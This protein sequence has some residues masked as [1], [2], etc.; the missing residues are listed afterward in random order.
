MLQAS[1]VS[2]QVRVGTKQAITIIIVDMCPIVRR[3]LVSL[4]HSIPTFAVVTDVATPE[5]AYI[6][7]SDGTIDIAMMDLDRERDWCGVVEHMY[8]LVPHTHIILFSAHIYPFQTQQLLALGAKG[9]IDKQ[10]TASQLITSIEQVQAGQEVVLLGTHI[11]ETQALSHARCKGSEAFEQLTPRELDAL[12]FVVKG[13]TNK[14]IAVHMH[15]TTKTIEAYLHRICAKLQ[16][17]SRTAAA[18]RGLQLGLV[19]AA[20]LYEM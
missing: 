14:E 3:S 19:Q 13:A 6:T 8:Y 18:I 16:V 5:D 11:Q 2:S 1:Y 12:G 4:L 17:S 10:V 20:N 15:V 9:I 7:L